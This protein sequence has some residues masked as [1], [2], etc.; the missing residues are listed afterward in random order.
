MPG[1]PG[2]PQGSTSQ[3]CMV[4]HAHSCV[5]NNLIMI[6]L[7]PPVALNIVLI[8]KNSENNA[9]YQ[10]KFCMLVSSTSV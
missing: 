6:C 9:K 10:P 7:S 4:T 1:A 8:K 3:H 2:G 5:S